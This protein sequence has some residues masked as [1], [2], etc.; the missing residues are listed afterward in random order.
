[1]IALEIEARTAPF[2]NAMLELS[3]RFDIPLRE[4]IQREACPFMWRLMFASPPKGDSAQAR[5]L[6]RIRSES[7]STFMPLPEIASMYA[8]KEY[9]VLWAS[10]STVYG[11]RRN[12]W[13]Q[14][15]DQA[16]LQELYA[17][18][19][20]RIPVRSWWEESGVRRTGSGRLSR[21]KGQQRIALSRRPVVSRN[22]FN[23]F[24]AE[25]QSHVGRMKAAWLEGWNAMAR[26]YQGAIPDW[27]RRHIGERRGVFENHLNDPA[28]PWLLIGNRAI[29]APEKAWP[30][31][32]PVLKQQGPVI[33][34]AIQKLLSGKRTVQDYLG[35]TARR[36]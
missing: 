26:G 27:V 18:R 9:R 23:I 17:Y 5:T 33:Q 13:N 32:Q 2:E 24:V 21:A 31:I 3:Q 20:K 19:S 30:K 22:A 36:F 10:Q 14:D 16:K 28:G 25:L 34:R 35:L 4:V 8:T 7:F 6:K 1:M 29:G 12:M 11:V 15:A